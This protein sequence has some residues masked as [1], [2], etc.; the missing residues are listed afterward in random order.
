M[1]RSNE[2]NPFSFQDTEFD[3]ADDEVD[4]IKRDPQRC[5]SEENLQK[6]K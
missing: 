6:K 5:L 2:N 1:D 4:K 3:E